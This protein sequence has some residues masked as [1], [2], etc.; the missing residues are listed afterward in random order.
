[1]L[2]WPHMAQMLG[3]A[4]WSRISGGRPIRRDV[5]ALH[6]S[7]VLCKLA[8]CPPWNQL[9][10]GGA[11][12]KVNTFWPRLGTGVRCSQSCSPLRHLAFLLQKVEIF[13]WRV[14]FYFF[15]AAS[16]AELQG[17][18]QYQSTILERPIPLY[19]TAQG[20]LALCIYK[21]YT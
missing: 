21:M 9:Q 6:L 8:P 13:L 7:T 16:F 18:C 11:A 15:F 1:M 10:L 20:L 14:I 5:K 12:R 3:C 19:S 17:V 4:S 2:D